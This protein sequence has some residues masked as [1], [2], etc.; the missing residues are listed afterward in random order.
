MS[1]NSEVGIDNSGDNSGVIVAMNTGII[2]YQFQNRKKIPSKLAI[3]VKILGAACADEDDS[4]SLSFAAFKPDEKIQYN[5][6]I[7][8]D[9]I[10]REYAT[11]FSQCEEAMNVY[12]NS[13]M[14]SK[15]RILRCIRNWYLEFKGE[16]LRLFKDDNK[17]DIEI[18]RSN[19]DVLIDKIS[20]KVRDIILQ[21]SNSIE[22]DH[23]DM[24]LGITSFVCYCFMKCK[25]LEKPL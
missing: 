8:Y 11:Y 14:G 23:E 12:D 15:R 10:I 20:Q 25:I 24:E 6:V 9:Q 4:Q 22:L 17:Q 5:C 21:S 16:L 3:I 1:K 7:K 13:S 19:A 2:N 18:V